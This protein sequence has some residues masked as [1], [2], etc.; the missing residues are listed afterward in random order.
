MVYFDIEEEEEELWSLL[1]TGVNK[2]SVRRTAWPYP[3]VA[4]LG[5]ILLH[6]LQGVDTMLVTDVL[7]G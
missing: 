3:R 6:P 2:V 7:A 4:A 5:V 1:G